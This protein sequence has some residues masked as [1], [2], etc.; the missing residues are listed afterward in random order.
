MQRF[1]RLQEMVSTGSD[2]TIF[3]PKVDGSGPIPAKLFTKT[4]DLENQIVGKE[5]KKTVPLLVTQTGT[6]GLMLLV[7]CNGS[8]FAKKHKRDTESNEHNLEYEHI[9]I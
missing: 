8:S 5:R 2:L 9:K 1:D 3:K 4:G 7:V 6:S